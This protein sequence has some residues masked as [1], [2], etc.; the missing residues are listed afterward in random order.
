[1]SKNKSAIWSVLIFYTVTYFLQSL[2]YV[3]NFA[4]AEQIA[5]STQIVSIFVDNEL[6]KRSDVRSDIIWYSKDYLQ[7][8]INSSKA[9]VIPV[10]INTISANDIVRMLENIYF[11]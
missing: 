2:L 8:R 6:Y 10:D 7:Q 4:N 9:I 11:D 1:M 5:Q 3:I